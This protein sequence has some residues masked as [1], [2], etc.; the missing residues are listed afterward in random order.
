MPIALQ[1]SQKLRPWAYRF[2]VLMGHDAR[3]LMQMRHVMRR[4]RRQKI[5]QRDRSEA[6]MRAAQSHL[7]GQ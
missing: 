5:A 1:Y 3:K 2:P 6:R 4:P 7:F